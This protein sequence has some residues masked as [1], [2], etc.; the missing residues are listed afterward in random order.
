MIVRG[1]EIRTL[2]EEQRG[3]ILRL[4][5]AAI[6]CRTDEGIF[7]CRIEA[8]L[9]EGDTVRTEVTLRR[10]NGKPIDVFVYHPPEDRWFIHFQ[11][12][13]PPL[14]IKDVELLSKPR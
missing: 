12:S 13:L 4:N 7:G 9:F 1:R 3:L 14:E 11:G 10:Y 8:C 6:M 5:Q 2:S